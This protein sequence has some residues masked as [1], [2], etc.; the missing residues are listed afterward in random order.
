MK[1]SI[2]FKIAMSK[3]A[4]S[5]IQIINYANIENG[6]TA[7]NWIHESNWIYVTFINYELQYICTQTAS[8]MVIKN[9]KPWL[10]IH[11]FDKTLV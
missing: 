10:H 9:G 8:V 7:H 2:Y 4:I 11:G 3:L 5:E 1:F 6:E